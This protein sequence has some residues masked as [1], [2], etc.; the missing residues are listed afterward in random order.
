MQD[1][2]VL[3][4]WRPSLA[5][6]VTVV[7]GLLV[8]LPFAALVGARVTSNQFV[9]ET[10]ASLHSQAAIYAESFAQAY[11][12]ASPDAV[13]GDPLSSA[14]RDRLAQDWHPV[15]ARLVASNA[16]ILP[17]RPDPTPWPDSPGAV[18]VTVGQTMSQLAAKARK[19]TLVGFLAL[20]AQG[21]IIA[22]S[23]TD[24]GNLSQIDEVA[25]ALGGEIVS[26]ARW[27]EDEYR[28]HSVRSVSRDTKFRVYV[29]HPVVV[30]DH[31]VGAI[32]LSRTPS[33]LNKYLFQQR[34]TFLWL[35]VSVLVS[36]ALIGAF[37]WRFLT[38]P[39]LQLQGQARDIANGKAEKPLPGYGVKELAGL[40]QSLIDMGATLRKNAASL[41]TYT[42]H[43]THELKSPVTSI[44]GAAELL[45][46]QTVQDA[47]RL[48]LAATI[49]TD[50]AR[51]N[52]L[53]IRMREMA[54]GQVPMASD[55][56]TLKE[57]LPLLSEKFISLRIEMIGALD[58]PLPLPREAAL[59]C[60]GHLLENATEHS[61]SSVSISYAPDS[62][63]IHVQ[64]DG[65]GIS[66]ANALKATEPFFTTK[67]ETGGTGM[68]LTICAEIIAQFHG[69]LSVAPCD[70]GMRIELAF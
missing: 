46:A 13:V 15:E 34:H 49:K 62:G 40:G 47:R 59:I 2:R 56:T 61:A 52:R 44:I 33:N 32:Y 45:E 19:T 70:K 12:A 17:P 43:A 51:M 1:V 36:A 4:K 16:T 58:R 5:L 64:D 68:G 67:R 14:Q 3:Q 28:N 39:I 25:R 66:V 18:Y 65:T 69:S 38:R 55:E 31:V 60:F 54:R 48:A 57:I 8:I 9:R 24:A 7:A 53:L 37:L 63:E 30:S 41:Q 22:K 10:E 11:R 21:T 35:A 50:A 29:A 20:D 23:G 6:L 42:K 27:R 26:V